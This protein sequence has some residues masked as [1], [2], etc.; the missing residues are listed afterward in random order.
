MPIALPD[1]D[2]LNAVFGCVNIA[3]WAD[4]D[5]AEDDDLIDQRITWAIE[6]AKNY[7]LGKLSRKFDV[8]AWTVFP[9]IPFDLV[10][11]LAG[12]ELYR[13]PRGLLDGTDTSSAII[14]IEQEV[15]RKLRLILAGSL[16]L[17]DLVETPPRNVPGVYNRISKYQKPYFGIEPDTINTDEL[18]Y[19]ETET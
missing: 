6:Q 15:D 18:P 8:S 16:D 12:L 17:I 5:N 10:V 7:V 11:R 14:G 9:A 1:V 3:K 13:T 4:A 2:D 19:I